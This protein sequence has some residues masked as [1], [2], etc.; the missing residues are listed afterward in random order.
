MSTGL[1]GLYPDAEIAASVVD[2]LRSAG[3]AEREIHIASGIPFP[4]GSFERRAPNTPLE[5]FSLL[6]GALGALA[7]FALAAGTALLYPIPTGHMDIVALFPVGIITFELAML[8]V[9]CFTFVG[10]AVML[11]RPPLRLDEP[12]LGDGCVGVLAVSDNGEQLA[13]IE[14]TLNAFE[15]LE[16]RPFPLESA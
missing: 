8:G 13:S 4:E 14:A 3:V 2:G 1:F 16:V 11:R 12:R 5:R 15:P 7:G 10:L 9:I 6:G